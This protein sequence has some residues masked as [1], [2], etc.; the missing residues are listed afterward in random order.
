VNFEKGENGSVDNAGT[1]IGTVDDPNQNGLQELVENAGTF[2][3]NITLGGSLSVLF[4]LGTINGNVTLG[5][6]FSAA[7]LLP[8]GKIN[9]N[10]VIA[11][12][13]GPSGL[14]LGGSG[15][16]SLS[17]AVAGSITNNGGLIKQDDGTWIID[18]PLDAPLGTVIEEGTLIVEA[19]L[20]SAQVEITQGAILQ[21][22]AGGSVGN[23]AVEGSLI[24][25]GSGTVTVGSMISGPG[26]VLQDGTGTTI[27]SGR[28]TYA[29]ARPSVSGPSW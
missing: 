18:R 6:A 8:G 1:L 24:F 15:Q 2:T 20:N 27:L 17:Q 19:S 25:A 14:Y 11:G 5:G 16:Q 28:N 7:L 29:A 12:A 23:L 9:G 10:L 4:N 13:G 26:E 3:G 22:D 21:L